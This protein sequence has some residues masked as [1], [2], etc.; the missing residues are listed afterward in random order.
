MILKFYH[1]LTY[2]AYPFVCVLLRK[3]LAHGKEDFRRVSE[4]KGFYKTPR[5]DG[6]LIWL[7]GAS[8][9]ECL[10]MMPLVNYLVSLP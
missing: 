4:R 5:P 3:R 8:V 6:K 7:H 9:G 2:L 1:Y 10:S